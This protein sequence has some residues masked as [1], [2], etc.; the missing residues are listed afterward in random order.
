MAGPFG[1]R[2]N[3]PLYIVSSTIIVILLLY[4]E[5]EEQGYDARMISLL[6]VMSSVTVVSR[7]I[8]HGVEFSPV[9]FLAI[10]IGYRFGF[11]PGFAVGSMVMLLSNF[12]LGHGPWTPFQMIGLGLCGGLAGLLPSSVSGRIR[13]GMLIIYC[14]ITAF[15]Y[16]LLLDL[17]SWLIFIPTHTLESYLAMAFA[18]LLANTSRAIGNILFMLVFADPV[19]KVMDRFKRRF[20]VTYTDIPEK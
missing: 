5:F 2:V 1:V 11:I 13:L 20:V 10:V 8:I 14:V 3:W 9:F 4:L 18:G 19:L 6:A 16:G 17:F 15:L 12:F 7:Q